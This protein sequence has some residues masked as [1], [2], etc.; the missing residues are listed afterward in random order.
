MTL[1]KKRILKFR[2]PLRLITTLWGTGL[3]HPESLA[4]PN[5]Q[6]RLSPSMAWPHLRTTCKLFS[7]Y[8]PLMI[9]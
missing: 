5:S 3:G 8:F 7:Y 2:D 1:E 6:H 9:F 4:M